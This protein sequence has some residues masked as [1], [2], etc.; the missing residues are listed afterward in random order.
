MQKVQVEHGV[1]SMKTLH[2]FPAITHEGGKVYYIQ[3][4]QEGFEK[5]KEFI[6]GK[7]FIMWKK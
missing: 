6:Y 4:V 3:V 7:L 2:F 5:K 1:Q